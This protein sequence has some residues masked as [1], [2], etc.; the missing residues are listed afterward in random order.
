MPVKVSLKAGK[1]GEREFKIFGGRM[2]KMQTER[3]LKYEH[4][5]HSRE[6]LK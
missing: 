6:S 2:H 1:R 3:R 5:R 4:M